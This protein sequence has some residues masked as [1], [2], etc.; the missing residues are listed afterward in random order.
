MNELVNGIV[1]PETHQRL[2]AIVD[3]LHADERIDGVILGG[4]ELS[5]L[6]RQPDHHGIP[7]LDTTQLHV[8]R[9]VEELLG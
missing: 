7:F 1:R 9:V 4:T 5:L 6:I 3:R 2:M 8:E